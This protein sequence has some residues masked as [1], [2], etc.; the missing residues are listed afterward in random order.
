MQQQQG[1]TINCNS[2]NKKGKNARKLL[3]S[4]R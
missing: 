1:I 2:R 3:Y 4:D